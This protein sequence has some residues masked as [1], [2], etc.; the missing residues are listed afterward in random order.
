VIRAVAE[1]VAVSD[2]DDQALI[3]FHHQGRNMAAG[4]D[5]RVHGLLERLQT[6]VE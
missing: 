6:F 1:K 4:N 2:F 5:V 3:T